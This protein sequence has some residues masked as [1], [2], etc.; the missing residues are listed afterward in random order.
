MGKCI[1]P[2]CPITNS[3]AEE[4]KNIIQ[5]TL[6]QNIKISL[7]RLPKDVNKRKLWLNNV[8]LNANINLK[9]NA[10]I[11]SLHFKE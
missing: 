2:G 5:K 3:A 7:H 8:G 9:K 1:V 10:S 6:E 11:C 4:H